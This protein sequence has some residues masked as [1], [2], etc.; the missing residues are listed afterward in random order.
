MR[1][2]SALRHNIYPEGLSTRL[3]P[4]QTDWLLIILGSYYRAARWM[5]LHWPAILTEPFF[6][7]LSLSL[8]QSR[9]RQPKSSASQSLRLWAGSKLACKYYI[10]ESTKALAGWPKVAP[11]AA[12]V[13][14]LWHTHKLEAPPQ[15]RRYTCN[16][17]RNIGRLRYQY[18]YPSACLLKWT[19]I[20]W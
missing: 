9:F 13:A 7:S 10:G 19:F 20:S 5:H 3:C 14:A 4:R 15:K 17:Q 12:Q 1:K 11:F 16:C 6:C 2:K 18:Y 8:V